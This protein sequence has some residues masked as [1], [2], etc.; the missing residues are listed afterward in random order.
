MELELS[1]DEQQE[2]REVLDG[3]LGDLSSEIAGTDN[4]HYRTTLN[5]RRDRLQAVRQRLG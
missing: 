2:L 5:Q 1:E 3:V 4:A